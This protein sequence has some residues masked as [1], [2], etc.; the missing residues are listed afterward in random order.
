MNKYRFI[1]M[2]VAAVLCG[3]GY[4]LP[5]RADMEGQMPPSHIQYDSQGLDN[6]GPVHVEAVQDA[7]GITE[8][9]VTAFGSPRVFQ[10]TQLAALRGDLFNALGVS[11]SR[12]N[13]IAGGR[14]VYILLCKVYSSG[15]EIVAIVTVPEKGDI[16]VKPLNRSVDQ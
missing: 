12:G 13:S 14:N 11:Y 3:S 7:G 16:R 8:L 2:F 10:G 1:L 4:A 5:A 15:A 9:R 6:S